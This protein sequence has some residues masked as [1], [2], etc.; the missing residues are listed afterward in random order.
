MYYYKKL[1]LSGKRVKFYV[2]E[3]LMHY[4]SMRRR[5]GDSL[6]GVVLPRCIDTGSLAASPQLGCAHACSLRVYEKQPIFWLSGCN[7]SNTASV[8]PVDHITVK[9]I[10]KASPIIPLRLVTGCFH[11]PIISPTRRPDPGYVRLVSKTSGADR[12]G[13]L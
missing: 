2:I 5:T 9:W 8:L 1:K 11:V 12:S 3:I 13:R 7:I 6:R 4:L 10:Y